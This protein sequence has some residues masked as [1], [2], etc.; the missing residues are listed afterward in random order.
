MELAKTDFFA[1]LD[2][3]SGPNTGWSFHNSRVVDNKPTQVQL[4]MKR[5]RQSTFAE[6][7][8]SFGDLGLA[9]PLLRAVSELGYIC[10]SIIQ[11]KAIPVFLK[12]SDLLMCA[13]TGSGK[14]AAFSL[15]ILH[16]LLYR[17]KH[18]QVTRALVLSPTRELSQQTYS[19]LKQLAQST[20]IKV[21]VVMG[22]ANSQS[23]QQL[24]HSAPD[25]M[26]GTPG[27]LL[28]HLKNSKGVAFDNLDFLVLDEA[29][30]LLDMGFFNE[31][32][33]IVE[34]LPADRQTVLASATLNDKVADLAA[35]ALKH[36]V[37]VGEFSMPKKL[38]QKIV[39]IRDKWNREAVILALLKTKFNAET[40]VFFQT[41]AQCHKFA[42]TARELGLSVA[43]L[44][45]YLTQGDRLRAIAD[46]QSGQVGV[47][48]ATD[49]ASRGLDLPVK[50][51]INYCLPKE[52]TR[53]LHRVGRT[54]RAGEDGVSITLV[55]EDERSRLKRLVKQ[56]VTA[57]SISQEA[58]VEAEEEI[59]N[60]RKQVYAV[61]KNERL[62]KEIRKAEV[63][64]NRA[65][66]MLMH[67]EEIYNKPRKTFIRK[68]QVEEVT[69]EAPAPKEERRE[70]VNRKVFDN[71][72]MVRQ[73][74]MAF[75]G[76]NRMAQHAAN[77]QKRRDKRLAKRAPSK[78]T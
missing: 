41:K 67:A 8:S 29:D 21:G 36:P 46:F 54:A 76:E 4:P 51:V 2:D 73:D 69:E 22:G 48:L 63:E 6:S 27:R 23:E 75:R 28:D 7:D 58:L 66:N 43:E 9:K 20:D 59:I 26:V 60:C 13:A 49:L 38:V 78:K 40:L 56:R 62:E 47:L 11:E 68:R 19:M 16:K 72:L 34:T 3:E 25:V 32:K 12:G 1:D 10:P 55:D 50:A 17:N 77:K 30:R 61:L 45:G 14:T 64:T 24:L 74:R 15:P 70:K 39:R 44:H 18:L 53:F 57:I 35:L 33:A 31:V 42:L 65:E 52:E 71:K 37:K 5:R